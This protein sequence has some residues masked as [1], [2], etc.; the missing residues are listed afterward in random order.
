MVAELV[1]KQFEEVGHSCSE[2]NR[3]VCRVGFPIRPQKQLFRIVVVVRMGESHLGVKVVPEAVGDLFE[4]FWTRR[5]GRGRTEVQ[6]ESKDGSEM[7]GGLTVST[8]VVAGE[9]AGAGG[10]E[11]QRLRG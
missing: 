2:L 1:A 11:V 3:Y 8:K 7:F 6:T 10:E 5:E 9:V 4:R